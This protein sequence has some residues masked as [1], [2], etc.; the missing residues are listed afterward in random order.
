MRGKVITAIVLLAI[1]A[2]LIGALYRQFPQEPVDLVVGEI[3]VETT[4]IIDYGATPVFSENLRFNHNDISY[5]IDP[6]CPADS[7]TRMVEAMGIL[8]DD[9][10]IVSFHEVFNGEP[11]IDINCSMDEIKLGENYYAAGEGGPSEII[12][13]SLFK[14]IL[15]GRVT[16]YK[17]IGCDYPIVE[18]H[19]LL[20][21]F[22]FDHSPNPKSI[23]Y[24][25]S[26]CKQRMT[27]D[28]VLLM[29]ELYSIKPRA[30][31]RISEVS[32]TK[33]GRYLDFNIT[34]LNEGLIDADDVSFALVADGEDAEEIEMGEIGIGFGRTLKA[35]NIKLPSRNVDVVE[36]IV[37]AENLID[38]IN[39][40]NNRVS[41][42]VGD[43]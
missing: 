32:A 20:H 7:R 6:D 19:E 34:V 2:F 43:S 35:T 13:T 31:L 21:V 25:T 23:M 41:L 1:L 3:P 28:M 22:G 30:D 12:N 15:N 29:Q 39:E 9:A 16:L 24:N 10:V 40:D 42:R 37:D 27:S 17:Q 26:A 14:T 33:H 11:D 4:R 36:L 5:H 8:S 38:E 18:L